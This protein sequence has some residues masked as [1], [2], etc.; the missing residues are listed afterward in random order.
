MGQGSVGDFY[1]GIRGGESF[2]K[3]L[4]VEIYAGYAVM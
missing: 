2:L 4:F 3:T 1:F